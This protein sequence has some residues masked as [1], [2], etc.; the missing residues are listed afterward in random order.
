MTQ[1]LRKIV[2]VSSLSR[3]SSSRE[4]PT[5]E[6]AA[7]AA[8][9]AP[10]C[11][12]NAR[13][14][15]GGE[16]VDADALPDDLLCPIT[17]E[18]FRDPVLL[19]GDGQTYERSAVEK[20]LETHD[21]SPI[22]GAKLETAMEK[23]LIPNFRARG[24][25]DAARGGRG[26]AGLTRKNSMGGREESSGPGAP[27]A[28][29]APSHDLPSTRDPTVAPVP[30]NPPRRLQIARNRTSD[31]DATADNPHLDRWLEAQANATSSAAEAPA[32]G[33]DPSPAPPPRARDQE[34]YGRVMCPYYGRSAYYD[35]PL[36]CAFTT[37]HRF[38][39]R[40]WCAFLVNCVESP[41]ML[42]TWMATLG[43]Q[44]CALYRRGR[45]DARAAPWSEQKITV[46]YARNWDD[47]LTRG[48]EWEAFRYRMGATARQIRQ[49]RAPPMDAS[50]EEDA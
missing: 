27:S 3:S 7:R 29:E 32:S 21:T 13:V 42:A 50:S 9:S 30:V 47:F 6:R 11:A 48:P 16:M 46:S 10:R 34:S 25:A 19:S 4:S 36:G 23:T 28:E 8:G 45:C 26:P 44:P 37:N 35:N 18:L 24:Q 5:T 2:V 43:W 17:G 41:V 12:V 14:D 31:V 38:G 20:W 1:L 33:S 39:T 22:S 49:A 15:V 40:T